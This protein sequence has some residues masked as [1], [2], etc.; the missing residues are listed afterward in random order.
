M[1]APAVVPKVMVSCLIQD[2]KLWKK[3]RRKRKQIGSRRTACSCG[4]FSCVSNDEQ[5]SLDFLCVRMGRCV[6]VCVCVCVRVCMAAATLSVCV[7]VCVWVTVY[8]YVTAP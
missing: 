1:E 8:I 5:T 4:F 7:C 6:C 2:N 3:G